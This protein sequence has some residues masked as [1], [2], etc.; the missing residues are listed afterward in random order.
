MEGL[1]EKVYSDQRMYSSS[2]CKAKVNDMHTEWKNLGGMDVLEVSWGGV[3]QRE[4]DLRVI[5][6]EPLVRGNLGGHTGA[7]CS[8]LTRLVGG[9]N[10]TPHVNTPRV[11]VGATGVLRW[12][13]PLE[14]HRPEG[15][16]P[17]GHHS[18][19]SSQG[20]I[21]P[22]GGEIWERWPASP[23]PR[24]FHALWNTEILPTEKKKAA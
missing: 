11:R 3:R 13:Q 7:N 18:L 4:T 19:H 16:G 8:C 21:D 12:P 22:A 15:R 14:K 1:I 9:F 23:P 2:V 5:H 17:G 20:A 24:I 6:P 10:K